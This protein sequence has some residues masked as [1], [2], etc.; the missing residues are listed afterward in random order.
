MREIG[1]QATELHAE[2]G[3][4]VLDARLRLLITIGPHAKLIAESAQA[5]IN[6]ETNTVTLDAISFPSTSDCEERIG[7]LMHIGD[8]VLVKG[9]RAMEMEHIVARL[10]G[11]ET[12]C[13][14]G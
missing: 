8:T 4:H 2:L 5:L 13:F 11:D 10:V 7:D 9:S 1:D 12:A 14:H 6:A 3:K